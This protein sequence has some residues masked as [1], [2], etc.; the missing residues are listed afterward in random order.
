M[1]RLFILALMVFTIA[2]D[3][4]AQP[5]EGR[6]ANRLR[7][8]GIEVMQAGDTYSAIS[9]FEEA[10]EMEPGDVLTTYL[11]ANA[12][13]R[14]RD[15]KKAEDWY[16]RLVS[17]DQGQKYPEAQFTL[18]RVM[19]MNA[20]YDDA[21]VEF[22][23]FRRNIE[24]S[25]WE[26]KDRYTELTKIEIEGAQ[27]ARKAIP[28]EEVLIDNMGRNINSPSTELAPYPI[29]RNQVLYASLKSDTI[30]NL[31][32]VADVKARARSYTSER[33]ED[34]MGWKKSDLF[35][36][37]LEKDGFH[38]IQITYNTTGDRIYFTRAVLEHDK[39]IASRI[40]MANLKDGEV[41]GEPV[42]LDFNSSNFMC[43]QPR[44]GM[45][46][47]KEVLFFVSNQSGGI[48]DWDIWYAEI[49]EDGT[50]AQPLNIGEPVNSIVDE[51]TPFFKDNK[52]YFS[53][54]GH[55]SIGGFDIF[56]S[57]YVDGSWKEPVNLGPGFNSRVDDL[58]F[59]LN[60]DEKDP[61]FGYLV[62]NRPG[63]IS[64]KS[65]TCCDDIFS[66]IMPD[67][68]PIML[69]VEVLAS[70][71]SALNGATL[72]L[73]DMATGEVVDE[74]TNEAGNHVLFTLF[75]NN[76]YRIQ[77]SKNGFGD[78]M[79]EVNTLEENIGQIK[80]PKDLTASVMLNELG[81]TVETYNKRTNEPLPG[82]TVS[83]FNAK[84]GADV[85]SKK[86]DKSNNFSFN[87]P[88]DQDY[89]VVAEKNANFSTAEERLEMADM[90]GTPVVKLYLLP[91]PEFVNIYF[92]FDQSNI[93]EDAAATLEEVAQTLKDY[94]DLV[95]QVGGHTDALG[96]NSYN[97]RLSARR[98]KAAVDFLV[99]KGIAKE[100][101][102]PAAKGETQ[103]VAPNQ[104]EEGK[105][106]PEGRQKNRR[107]EFKIIQGPGAGEAE[108]ESI[109]AVEKKNQ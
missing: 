75:R 31:D 3:A 1:N 82:V 43:K 68:C 4:F 62:S 42:Q 55:P 40:F 52:L 85:A 67:Q 103:P 61:C 66:L 10:L 87:V 106:N 97:D 22:K 88:R 14:L 11:V 95:V 32:E 13:Y 17:S 2:Q 64:L 33:S 44:V 39:P 107:V 83:I 8:K 26:A 9:L 105:D 41:E 80:A 60:D 71:N 50:T 109:G 74:Q 15:Y 53:S 35:S 92:D 59:V 30:I 46:N 69:D 45:L 94:P 38:T 101:L 79:T 21:I 91:L 49:K 51:E 104:T 73:I 65:E 47:G 99:E 18:A 90:A 77:A 56:Y 7:Q 24:N 86:N 5:P 89:R 6:T 100:R 102:V 19:K 58:Y 54:T 72:K 70:D 12:H 76:K 20:K 28:D 84:S 16:T 108:V 98:S 34:E 96:S 63:T 25:D 36:K 81:F 78:G 23:N 48:G 57:E 27:Y 93:R 37:S 29:D